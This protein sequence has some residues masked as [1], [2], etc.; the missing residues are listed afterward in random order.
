MLLYKIGENY[1]DGMDR[2]KLALVTSSQIKEVRIPQILWIEYAFLDVP[3]KVQPES[4]GHLQEMQQH[5][6]ATVCKFQT[7]A[8]KSL[9]IAH[10]LH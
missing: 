9:Q 5:R 2:T 1:L 3:A 10:I 4:R 7:F 8:W 6:T